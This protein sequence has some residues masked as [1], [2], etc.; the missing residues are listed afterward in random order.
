MLHIPIVIWPE[1]DESFQS[2]IRRY[3]AALD[4][5][6]LDLYH[7]FDLTD[8]E[9][10]F[11]ANSHGF[12]LP[13]EIA[14]KISSSTDI[15][16]RELRLTSFDRY[17]H[18]PTFEFDALQRLRRLRHWSKSKHTR[19]CIPCLR[20][21]G[22][23]K[24]EWQLGWTFACVEHSTVLSDLC[25]S[26]QFPVAVAPPTK[27]RAPGPTTCYHQYGKQSSGETRRPYCRADLTEGHVDY[28]PPEHPIIDAQIFVSALVQSTTA[29]SA[30]LA[31]LRA[32]C[33]ALLTLWDRV[34]LEEGAQL[35]RG[36][37]AGLEPESTRI[38]ATV[39]ED[40][41]FFAALVV[42]AKA[43]L[44]GTRDSDFRW[45]RTLVFGGSRSRSTPSTSW[46]KDGPSELIT[47]FGGN[48][49]TRRRIAHA[50]DRDLT[51]RQR[52]WYG[53]TRP[54][55]DRLARPGQN[56]PRNVWDEWVLALD[57]Q[58]EYSINAI[59]RTIDAS[60]LLYNER[61]S[62]LAE[63]GPSSALAGPSGIKGDFNAQVLAADRRSSGDLLGAL[64]WLIDHAS[65]DPPMLPYYRRERLLDPQAAGFLPRDHW[66]HL[67]AS[68][69]GERS[70][71]QVYG[72]ART[73]MYERLTGSYQAVTRPHPRRTDRINYSRPPNT[74]FT[75]ALSAQLLDAIDRYL[76]CVLRIAGSDA[77]VREVP[78]TKLLPPGLAPGIIMDDEFIRRANAVCA[79]STNK[80]AISATLRIPDRLAPLVVAIAPPVR[81]QHH[82]SNADWTRLTRELE[83]S[84]C[85]RTIASI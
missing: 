43:L 32:M 68:V 82:S 39:P 19:F 50:I 46:W 67:V 78:S 42:N 75:S 26:C 76:E 2:W 63:G 6:P 60:L 47:A 31:D 27:I 61:Q 33:V 48:E 77:P 35:E 81:A 14:A 69:G 16:I 34:A 45:L 80:W 65:D 40:A 4:V 41:L 10:S 21:S 52:V 12:R 18:I 66:D 83:A 20:H 49:H 22:V 9:V 17:R 13:K 79:Q 56:L 51:Y 84:G 71:L 55:R 64:G 29:R 73:W 36:A 74:E 24:L 7:A 3:A 57:P 58:G 25:W 54:P 1:S 62:R 70:T 15:S 85:V 72:Q 59:R 30:N 23:F 8:S 38:G 53:S 11:V 44:M 5:T 37:L 28:L